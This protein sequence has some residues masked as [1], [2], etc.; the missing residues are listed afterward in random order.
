MKWLLRL[1]GGASAPWASWAKPLPLHCKKTGLWPIGEEM[2]T[3]S[4]VT[5]M[6]GENRLAFTLCLE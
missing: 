5:F 2:E 6:D 1:Q 3:V 4:Q